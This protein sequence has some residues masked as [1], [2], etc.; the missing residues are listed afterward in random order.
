MMFVIVK[1]LHLKCNA[2]LQIYKCV[3][4]TMFN[5]RKAWAKFKGF[6]FKYTC[7]LHV[8]LKYGVY[9]LVFELNGHY[10]ETKICFKV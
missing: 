4:I 10:F 5:F 3:K 6:S 9:N 1:I 7:P 2:H 8:L